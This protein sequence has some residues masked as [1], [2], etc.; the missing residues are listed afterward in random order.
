MSRFFILQEGSPQVLKV[1]LGS[2]ERL[3]ASSTPPAHVVGAV[4]GLGRHTGAVVFCGLQGCWSARP[5]CV[6]QA[7]LLLSAGSD[8]IPYQHPDLGSQPPGVLTPSLALIKSYSF[9][10]ILDKGEN[11]QTEKERILFHGM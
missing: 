6:S 11:E 1:L 9:V 10:N 5:C 7:I 4:F 8:V 3:A 2:A